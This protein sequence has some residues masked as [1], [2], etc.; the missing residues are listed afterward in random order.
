[1]SEPKKETMVVVTNRSRHERSLIAIVTPGGKGKPPVEK[2]ELRIPAASVAIVSQREWKLYE[3]H[4]GT[5]KL[6]GGVVP[7]LVVRERDA[8]DAPKAEDF[9]LSELHLADAIETVNRCNDIE[10]LRLMLDNERRLPAPLQHDRR[11]L[12][13]VIQQQLHRMAA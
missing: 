12:V 11:E 1:M 9:D 2:T 7:V 6:L 8:A 10:H 3:K 5:S 13:S 4:P